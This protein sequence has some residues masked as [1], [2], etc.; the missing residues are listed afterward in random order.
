M[1]GYLRLDL[2][3]NCNIRCIMCQAYNAQPV[4]AMRFFDFDRF[5]GQTKGQL[6]QW[7]TIQ[8]GNVA[9]ATVHPRF[10]D[11]L[12][13]IRSESDATIHI[14]TNG[15]LLSRHA[16]LINDIGNCLVQVSMDSVNKASHE[17]I[18][19]GRISTASLPISGC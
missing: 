19:A 4:T 15:K 7:S 5:I 17:Y 13:Y 6:A 10:G 11:F 12:K 2:T 3:D 16:G 8:L 18:R 9:E 1:R 14:V